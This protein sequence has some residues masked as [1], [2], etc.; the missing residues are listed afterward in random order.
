M[1][2]TSSA[3][4]SLRL[5]GDPIDVVTGACVEV[6]FEFQLRGPIPFVF[7]RHYDSSRRGHALSLGWGHTHEYD[8]T[9]GFDVD[10]LRY[11]TP[12]AR[13]VAFPPLPA[14]G[15]RVSGHGRRLIRVD[16]HRYRIREPDRTLAEFV[17]TAFDKPAPL[18]SL[19]RGKDEIR[20]HYDQRG[21]LAGVRDS[22]GR[23]LAVESDAAGRI[24]A[25]ARVGQA[26]RPDRFLLRFAYDPA[27]HLV[28]G[29][30][31]H[32]STFSFDYDS[33]GRLIR[34]TDRRGYAFHYEYDRN[35]RCVRSRGGDGL[36]DVR[37]R[38][39]PAERVTIV[40]R[41]D[42]GE[43][44]YS[45]DEGGT[46]TRIVDPY[47]GTRSFDVNEHGRVV[48]EVDPNG[49][50]LDWVYDSTG[51]SLGRRTA[52]GELLNDSDVPT[53]PTARP[54]RI[55]G[56]PLE[57]EYGHLMPRDRIEPPR[58]GDPLA[59]DLPRQS[60]ARIWT[61]PPDPSH[62]GGNEPDLRREGHR[63]YELLG[64]RIMEHKAG[65]A[66]RRW[67]YD[68]G[69][70]TRR[71]H[72]HDG[73]V[74]GY[75]YTSWDLRAAHIDPLGNTTRYS[76]TASGD[77]ASV[78]DPGGTRTDYEYDLKNRLIRVSRHGELREQYRY[79]A[80]DNLVEKLDRNGDWLLRFEI[81]P[82]NARLTR[83]LASGGTHRFEYDERGRFTKAATD[84]FEVTF[85]YDRFGQ[86]TADERD[87]TGVRHQFRG[88]RVLAR[89]SVLGKFTTTYERTREGSII[90]RDPAGA[91]QRIEF[92]G[93]GLVRRVL[94]NGT[95]ETVQFDPDGRRRMQHGQP[96][97]RGTGWTRAWD[98]SGEGDLLDADEESGRVRF[99]YDAAHR[100]QRVVYQNGSESRYGYDQAGNLIEQPGLKG[101]RL[102]SGN[103][104]DA[105]NGAAFEYNRRNHIAVRRTG[106][107]ETRYDF[108]SRD[109]LV[110]VTT[111]AGE[112]TAA[113][114]PLARRV[115]LSFDGRSTAF[116]WD[117][118]RLA[119]EVHSD[120]RVRVYVYPDEFSIVPMMFVDYAGV[121]ASPDSGRRHFVFC[122]H[123]GCPV[124][125]EDDDGRAVWSG[126]MEPYGRMD[127]S[128]QASIDFALRFPGH[129]HDAETGL[130]YNRLRYY[131]PVLGRYLQT[132]PLGVDGNINVYAYCTTNP[133]RQVDVRGDCGSGTTDDDDDDDGTSREDGD[134][135][136]PTPAQRL[137]ARRRAQREQRRQEALADAIAKADAEGRLDD[138]SPADRAWLEAEPG[139]KE[140][141][142]DLDGDGSYRVQE[143]RDAQQAETDEQLTSPVRRAT[144]R[145]DEREAGADFIDGDDGLWDH[146][147]QSMGAEDIAST[148]APDR[149]EPENVI[150]GCSDLSDDDQAALQSDVDQ[151]VED[152]GRDDAGDVI[153]VPER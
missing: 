89:T 73:S 114:D 55:P 41:A 122:N 105:A 59:D 26:G 61:R 56:C 133:L 151:R 117:T 112:W 95:R 23:H 83:E 137:A 72:D 84:D 99:E 111:S 85:E 14:D 40:T 93:H 35:D 115:S 100:L 17:F 144:R 62:N 136:E 16:R 120:G 70:N 150:V 65:H 146:K 107:A 8:R 69:A 43:W 10:G 54:H 102:A 132:D 38:Y 138:L 12:V 46:V 141:A 71:F 32:G 29:A 96:A 94:S 139:R 47:G 28:R 134:D 7:R 82:G 92:P 152:S 34:R 11:T 50:A 37:L 44:L 124:R 87:G 79:D 113:Y 36:H 153:F 77:I 2:C 128:P 39:L 90:V 49:N 57:W 18:D 64:L 126:R 91:R 142:I 68:E 110:R 98:Y 88:P 125:V 30:D 106:T 109:Q 4:D 76:H 127:V 119:A 53:H 129:Y 15:D 13:R 25:I 67:L 75:E 1:A 108:D 31:A 22:A 130:H 121:D 63:V 123:L 116:Y 148:A 66:P 45:Y 20:F 145:A 51:A 27:G 81:G 140:L 135:A 33:S 118:D 48:R 80:A 147:D 86:R 60:R 101:V 42:G 74:H 19:K 97:K 143:A 21:R 103:R 6:A 24:T 3:Y 78:T 9:L 104:L 5:V 149:G 58:A 131:D 52:F